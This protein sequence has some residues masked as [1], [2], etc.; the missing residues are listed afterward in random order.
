M[1]YRYIDLS[2]DVNLRVT[3]LNLG[4]G[5]ESLGVATKNVHYPHPS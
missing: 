5:P 4:M 2:A 1:I 3:I